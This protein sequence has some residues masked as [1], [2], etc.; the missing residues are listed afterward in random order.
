[1]DNIISGL[2][3]VV[4]GVIVGWAIG[5]IRGHQDGIQTIERQAVHRNVGTYDADGKFVWTVER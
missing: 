1:M 4:G 3:G 2:I 5:D